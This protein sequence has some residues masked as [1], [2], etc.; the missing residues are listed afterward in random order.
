MSPGSPSLS[1]IE[2][3]GIVKMYGHT[4]VLRGASF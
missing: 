1:L 2:A 3:R 4:P